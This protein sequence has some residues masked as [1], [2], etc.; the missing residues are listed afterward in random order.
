[1]DN[2]P[3]ILSLNDTI[4][5]LSRRNPKWKDNDFCVKI[6]IWNAAGFLEEHADEVCKEK[7]PE[8]IPLLMEYREKGTIKNEKLPVYFGLV[9]L[10]FIIQPYRD[11]ED[12]QNFGTSPV[13]NA[14]FE[15]KEE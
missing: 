1:M 15:I 4:E 3:T 12:F 11:E 13:R 14:F 8:F 6:F 9:A 10:D 5:V 7:C 2:E